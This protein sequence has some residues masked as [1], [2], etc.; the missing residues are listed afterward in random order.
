MPC[1]PAVDDS[2]LNTIQVQAHIVLCT[3]PKCLSWPYK[4]KGQISEESITRLLAAVSLLFRIAIVLFRVKLLKNLLPTSFLVSVPECWDIEMALYTHTH[5]HNELFN[6]LRRHEAWSGGGMLKQWTLS[7]L[8]TCVV[9]VWVS[10]FI[11]KTNYHF[12]CAISTLFNE[13]SS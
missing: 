12:W 8:Q 10:I 4:F 13:V 11:S 5:I 1:I 9:P 2:S 6:I 3:V 7:L